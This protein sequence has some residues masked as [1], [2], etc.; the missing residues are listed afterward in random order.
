MADMYPPSL[1]PQPPMPPALPPMQPPMPPPGATEPPIPW[2]QPNFPA[3]EGL[4]ET[5]KLFLTTPGDA[6]RRMPVTGE[7][8][9][10]LGY[11]IILGWVGIIAGQ[12]YNIAL[13][14]PMMN[15]M[16]PF[17][18]GQ[19]FDMGIGLNIAI[20]IAAPL[21]M[22]VGV[23][24]S[25]AIIHVFLMMV[26]GNNAG[27]SATTRVM[28]YATS[29]QILQIVP[30]C[31]GLAGGIWAIVLEVIGLAIAHRTTQGKAATAVLLPLVICCVCVAVI[32]ALAGAAILAAIGKV[33]Q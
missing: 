18:Q 21:L 22:L 30:L 29:V 8:G 27:F 14:G 4:Y 10:P 9:R 32:I 28:C 1:P 12:A 13:R 3:L 25:A 31:G 19:Q 20:M 5:V 2:E 17:S 11:A 23:F 15:L 26:G 7:L 6:F 16:A 33:A 24:V